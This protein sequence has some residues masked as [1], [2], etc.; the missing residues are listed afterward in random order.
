MPA[1]RTSW[2][3]RTVLEDDRGRRVAEWM[4]FDAA[5]S[6][7]EHD[8]WEQAYCLSGAGV[9]EVDGH[10]AVERYKIQAGQVLSVR[11]GSPHR[12]VPDE[13][14]PEPYEFLVYY[15]EAY[16]PERRGPAPVLHVGPDHPALSG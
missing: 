1:D 16:E 2:G 11:P 13:D 3:K 12:M 7:H 8:A 10:E 4:R 5:G 14:S 9:V 6:F 15:T